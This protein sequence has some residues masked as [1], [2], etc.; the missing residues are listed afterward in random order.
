MQAFPDFQFGWL[1]DEF[2]H[3]VAME[4]DFE[5]EARN[6]ERIARNFSWRKQFAVPKVHWAYTKK[7]ILTMEF[8]EG[9]KITDA[10]ALQ[11]AGYNLQDVAFQLVDLF[12]DQVF[13]HGFVHSDPHPGNILVRRSVNSRGR[14]VP[15]IV[16]L[17]HGLYRKLDEEVRTNYCKL[18]KALVMGNARDVEIYGRKLGAG[19]FCKYLA[20][21]LT[22]RPSIGRLDQS[23]K[24]E[25]EDIKKLANEV[26]ESGAIED[27]SALLESLP[28]DLLLVLRTNDLIMSINKELGFPVNR[29][30]VMAR[31]AIRGLV[32]SEET[33]QHFMERLKYSYGIFAFNLRVSFFALVIRMYSAYRRWFPA[34][35]EIKQS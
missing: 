7:R 3:S 34:K 25:K 23:V 8:I 33:S 20:M 12:S 5:N 31:A 17:D 19:D 9:I 24:I 21:M 27:I 22:F 29:F 35:A 10:K 32:V 4:L 1:V 26:W 18:W 15:E 13:I 2:K 30:L 6:S 11:A 14:A 16:L 28:R